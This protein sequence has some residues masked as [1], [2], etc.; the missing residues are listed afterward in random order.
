MI[1]N[2]KSAST[3]NAMT[4]A[5]AP[6]TAGSRLA[7]ALAARAEKKANKRGLQAQRVESRVLH[8]IGDAQHWLRQHRRVTWLGLGATV[9]VAAGLSGWAY[10][11]NRSE[12]DAATRVTDLVQN[13]TVWTIPGVESSDDAST[14]ELEV[15]AIA[16]RQRATQVAAALAKEVAKSPTAPVTPWALLARANALYESGDYAAA[17][18]LFQQ[19]FAADGDNVVIAWR[20]LEGMALTYEAQQA[21]SE[22][23]KRYQQIIKLAKGAFA[24][25]ARYALA[26]VH[27]AKGDAAVAR[28]E[29]TALTKKLTG[30]TRS[31]L[32]ALRGRAERDLRVLE[33]DPQALRSPPLPPWK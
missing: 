32:A 26:R 4:N 3:S 31:D 17:R 29:L 6:R 33:I 14:K 1:D 20:S 13:A 21:W 8:R 28:Q 22:A 12:R 15:S 11:S 7:M 19:S 24:D 2:D 10:T 18:R 25:P 30:E 27:A 23:E 9:L 5:K 16:A